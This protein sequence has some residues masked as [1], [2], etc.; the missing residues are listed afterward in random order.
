MEA[1][2]HAK[3]V[4]LATNLGSIILFM[5]KG[6]IIWL[7]ALPMAVSNAL[8]AMLGVRMAML[9]GNK[10]IRIVFLCVIILTLLRFS[11][12]VFKEYF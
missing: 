4:N 2:A 1:S 6:K 9:K 3:V 8:G 12:D 10:F 11:Y 5:I 7:I